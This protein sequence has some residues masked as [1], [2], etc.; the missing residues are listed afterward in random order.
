MNLKQRDDCVRALRDCFHKERAK[1]LQELLSSLDAL[2]PAGRWEIGL[3]G[4]RGFSAAA[5]RYF[6]PS[7]PDGAARA[8]GLSAPPGAPPAGFPRLAFVWDFAGAA[9]DAPRVYG[10]ELK[11][12]PFRPRDFGAPVAPALEA[13]AAL[14]PVHDAVIERG[15]ARWALRLAETL[16]W[17]DFL[18]LDIAAAFASAGGQSALLMRDLRVG[19]LAFDGE[20]LWAH[21]GS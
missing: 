18:R 2:L 13:F 12:R 15:S 10:A 14:C 5:L 20:A 4:A 19:E 7:L 21:A 6:G 3:C 9:L 8:L 16:C 11:A 17:P 1:G